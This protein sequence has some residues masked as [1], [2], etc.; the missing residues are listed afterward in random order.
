M[1]KRNLFITALFMPENIPYI[2]HKYLK[3]RWISV[4]NNK[5]G[6]M[7]QSYTSN[8]N[9]PVVN[10]LPV[11]GKNRYASLSEIYEEYSGNYNYLYEEIYEKLKREYPVYKPYIDEDR[12]RTDPVY[13]IF[14]PFDLGDGYVSYTGILTCDDRCFLSYSLVKE[15]IVI[16]NGND[17]IIIGMIYPDNRNEETPVFFMRTFF[18]SLQDSTEISMDVFFLTK[19]SNGYL[20]ECS[21]EVR[22]LFRQGVALGYKEEDSY[23]FHEF[24][25]RITY[26]EEGGLTDE[27]MEELDEL[28]WDTEW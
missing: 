17:S 21:G 9:P 7:D 11:P 24:T 20:S 6:I 5:N 12:S 25:D 15:F 16:G 4:G 22:W 28:L 19:K 26:E 27:I 18:E 8:D 1:E 2:R 23:V 14:P 10:S 13:R 3:D